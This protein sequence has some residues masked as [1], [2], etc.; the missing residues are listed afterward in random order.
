[1]HGANMKIPAKMF[2]ILFTSI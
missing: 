2:I 1:M